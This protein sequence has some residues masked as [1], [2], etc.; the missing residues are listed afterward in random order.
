MTERT[1]E[2][3]L[4]ASERVVLLDT[5][6]AH[7]RFHAAR[8]YFRDEDP[9]PGRSFAERIDHPMP[10]LPWSHNALVTRCGRLLRVHLWIEPEHRP[11]G[12]PVAEHQ[13]TNPFGFTEL[14][15]DHAAA[16][17]APCRRCWPDAHSPT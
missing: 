3:E 2:A 15:F 6:A 17:A 12:V 7:P 11:Q 16:F 8:L 10:E 14:R 5:W 9:P 13:W 1:P 4:H